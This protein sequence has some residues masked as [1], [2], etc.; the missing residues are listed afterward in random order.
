MNIAL[1]LMGGDYAPEEVLAGIELYFSEN[2]GTQVRILMLGD[3]AQVNSLLPQFAAIKPDH[4]ELIHCTEKIGYNE[5]P[6]KALKAKPDSSI[7]KGFYLL[8]S[9]KA[10]AFASAGNTGAMMAGAMFSLRT[11]PN[12]LRPTIGTIIPREGGK[13][14]FLLDV[15]IHSDCKPE[16]INQF[17]IIGSLYASEILGISNPI[18]GLLNIG[19]EEGKGNALAKEAY[20]LLK[21]ND[22][23]NF[24]GNIEGRDILRDTADV[25]V[26]DGFVGNILLKLLESLHPI[27][28]EQGLS[29][30]YLNRFD[31][32]Q[33]GGT[34]I[35]GIEKPVLIAHGVSRR[36]AYCNMIG[37]AVRIIETGFINKI[38]E[39]L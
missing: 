3:E 12:V 27:L 14:G 33:Y 35:L 23:I 21:N 38:S 24:Y 7:A 29:N 17:A 10:D 32:E 39:R 30:D 11:S 28:G 26:C 37:E 5:S 13:T 15:G 18:V 6:A 19:E 4:Y 20:P 36:E 25:I 22:K 16:N 34:P 9:G 31:F 2:S 8:A 1:D